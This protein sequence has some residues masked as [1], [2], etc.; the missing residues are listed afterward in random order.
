[1]KNFN[2]VCILLGV[3]VIAYSTRL[4]DASALFSWVGGIGVLL[5]L[6]GTV[7]SIFR[8]KKALGQSGD[9]HASLDCWLG[10]NEALKANFCADDG[11]CLLLTDKRAVVLL[12]RNDGLTD[13][14]QILWK[15]LI[16]VRQV[17]GKRSSRLDINISTTELPETWSFDGINSEQAAKAY[18]YLKQKELDN[19]CKPAPPKKKELPPNVLHINLH[20]ETSQKA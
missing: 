4:T 7:M 9:V 8:V 16:G 10:D 1:M 18:R 3:S 20:D 14:A 6:A 19:Q 12:L 13:H 15:Q 17:R 5:F 11:K 2:I